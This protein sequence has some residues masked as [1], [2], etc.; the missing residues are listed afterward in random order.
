MSVGRNHWDD[1]SK[2]HDVKIHD[3]SNR[4]HDTR[5]NVR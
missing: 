4:G 3:L 5:D 2:R 1:Q